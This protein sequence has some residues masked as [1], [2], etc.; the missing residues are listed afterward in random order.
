V[1]FVPFRDN[2]DHAVKHGVRYVAQP[3]GSDFDEEIETACREHGVTMVHTGV[4]L[5]HH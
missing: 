2:T 3:G 4:R 5:F 1:G